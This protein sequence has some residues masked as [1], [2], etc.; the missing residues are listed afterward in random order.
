VAVPFALWHPAME[1]KSIVSRPI[2]WFGT[3]KTSE[4]GVWMDA[5]LLIVFGGI[6]WQVRLFI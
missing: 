5:A 3:L 1:G 6:P 2:G 4:L